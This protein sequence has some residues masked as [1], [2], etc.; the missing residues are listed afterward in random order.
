[1][2]IELGTLNKAMLHRTLR[3]L[4]SLSAASFVHGFAIIAQTNQLQVCR[5]WRR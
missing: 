5:K 1:M 2:G 3:A 4:D